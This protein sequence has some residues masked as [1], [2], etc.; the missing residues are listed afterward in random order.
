[1]KA[2]IKSE[3]ILH[4]SCLNVSPKSSEFLQASAVFAKEQYF[5]FSWKKV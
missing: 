1:M 3:Y 2:Y 4:V 5:C